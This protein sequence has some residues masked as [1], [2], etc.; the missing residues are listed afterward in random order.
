MT[1]ERL[2]QRLRQAGQPGPRP[3]TRNALLGRAARKATARRRRGALQHSLL[4]LAGVL[5]AVNVGF[6]RVHAH[7]LEALLGGSS[8]GRALDAASYAQALR[9]RSRLLAS[10]AGDSDS[11]EE[12]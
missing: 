5:I 11:R 7:R 1:P 9:E 3:T 4:A 2:E 10:L 12:G 8:S 6:D